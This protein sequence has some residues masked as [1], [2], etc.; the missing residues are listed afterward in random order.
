[1]LF[2]KLFDKTPLPVWYLQILDCYKLSIFCWPNDDRYQY[3]F[4]AAFGNQPSK[5]F[6]NKP[7]NVEMLEQYLSLDYIKKNGCQLLVQCKVSRLVLGSLRAE[8]IEGDG[9][10]K[11]SCLATM[12][13]VL[14]QLHFKGVF[15]KKLGPL[16]L[17][18]FSLLLMQL[19]A[20]G[21]RLA[22]SDSSKNF[23]YQ[24]G[25]RQNEEE[26]D[27][28][29]S[30]SLPFPD[31]NFYLSLLT[32]AEMTP[33]NSDNALI[34]QRQWRCYKLIQLC[35]RLNQLINT[36]DA[37]RK[38][39]QFQIENEVISKIINYIQYTDSI[40]EDD[41]KLKCFKS[42]IVKPIIAKFIKGK[43][44]DIPLIRELIM[45]FL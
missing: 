9:Y 26:D 27:D 31:E 3:F 22:A 23:Y 15:A 28:F 45:G 35:E 21:Y 39:N 10:A 29:F 4:N 18:G 1:M 41:L 24:I 17:T 14:L 38:T 12:R 8:R 30:P 40:T 42:E 20:R 5:I 2:T 13:A 43:Y 7:K 16:L 32:S 25:M 19:S 37:Y 11:I 36:L 44:D 33:V 34:I 6:E